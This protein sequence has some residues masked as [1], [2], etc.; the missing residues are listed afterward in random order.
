MDSSQQKAGLWQRLFPRRLHNHTAN[1]ERVLG[2]SL[3]LQFSCDHPKAGEAA[4]KQALS[5][6]D[7]LEAIFNTY[8]PRSELSRWQETYGERVELSQDLAGVLLDAEFL[9]EQ[10]QGTFNPVVEAYTRLW[11]QAEAE[12]QLPAPEKLSAIAADLAKP[13]WDFEE[14]GARRLTKLPMTLNSIAKGYI[15]DSAV[16]AAAAQGGVRQALVNIGGDLAHLGDKSITV[17]IADPF[18]AAENAEPVNTVQICNQGL[19]TSGNYRRGFQ[20][21]DKWYSHVIDPRSGWPVE[22]IVSAS[23]IAN[24]AERADVYATAF[25]VLTPEESLE[26]ADS[27]DDVGVLIVE[28]NGREIANSFWKRHSSR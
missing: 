6:I 24:C 11:K 19:A 9:M 22:H 8:S 2:T 28:E 20:I 26:M 25:S 14:R 18:S 23:V 5:E 7:R 1:Y 21:G 17:A 16:K 12:Q 27:M 10:S 3:E 4:E 15:I 13:L